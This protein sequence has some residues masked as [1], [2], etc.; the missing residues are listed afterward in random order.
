MSENSSTSIPVY[1]AGKT[2]PHAARKPISLPRLA[3]IDSQNACSKDIRVIDCKVQTEPNDA[4]DH[5]RNIDP[6]LHQ[7][8]VNQ[9]KLQ[10]QR[11]SHLFAG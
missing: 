6:D 8:K 11:R 3:D 4:G 7:P 9:I 5:G 2:T 1:G 10:E